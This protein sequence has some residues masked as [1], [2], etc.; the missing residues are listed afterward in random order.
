MQEFQ[1]NITDVL[2][3]TVTVSVNSKQE[4]KRMAETGRKNADS[5]LD[6]DDF[7]KVL[8]SVRRD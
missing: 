3:K 1:V 4:A 5:V 7:K 6:T 2:Q 8:F